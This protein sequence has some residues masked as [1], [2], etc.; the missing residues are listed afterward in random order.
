MP[1]TPTNANERKPLYA[2][3]GAADAA[4]ETLREL[5]GRV[6]EAVNDEKLRTEIRERF[7]KL[8]ADAKA[9]RE[10]I[11]GF[12][13]EA[14]AKAGEV[15]DRVRELIGQASREAAKLY[16][17]LAR[18]GEGA[19]ARWRRDH[20]DTVDKTVAAIRGKVAGAADDV[21][22]AADKVADELGETAD[23]AAKP[24]AKKATKAG[25]KSRTP[26]A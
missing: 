11:P 20:G 7:A 2:L 3:A 22:E 9:L 23:A 14:P 10:E 15:P 5:P 13:H 8:P 21:A 16:E 12:V 24:A 26:K 1:E 25:S 6:S 19:V 4:V 17:E 18:R